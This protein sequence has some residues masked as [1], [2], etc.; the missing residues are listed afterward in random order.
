MGA[1]MS[2]DKGGGALAELKSSWLLQYEGSPFKYACGASLAAIK[3][4]NGGA[5]PLLAL[6][7]QASE[8]GYE[9]SRAQHLRFTTSKDGGESWE[10]SKCVMW[11]PAP[12]W[13]P[14]L[15]Y[16]AGKPRARAPSCSFQP[17]AMGLCSLL[18]SQPI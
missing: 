1:G 17:V 16:D 7:Y 12:L 3:K 5:T 8:E 13:N 2:A 14:T 4:A 9:G 18:P 11:G 10:E 15:H 6:A